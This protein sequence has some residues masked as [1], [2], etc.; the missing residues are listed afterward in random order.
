MKRFARGG[1]ALLTL[2]V[3]GS[4]LR[5]LTVN[6]GAINA[7]ASLP[8]NPLFVRSGRIEDP[9]GL[10]EVVKNGL[11]RLGA[12]SGP[13]VAA[14]PGSQMIIR[15]I[16]VPKVKGIKPDVVVPGEV[17]RVLGAAA[18]Q[19][20]TFW[21]QLAET[22]MDYRY[23]VL[24]VPRLDMA[25]FAEALTLAGLKPRRIEA[26]PLALARIVDEDAAV[27]LRVESA[28]IDVTAV[29][30]RVPH[31]VTRKNLDLGLGREDLLS[32]IAESVQ[33]TV[34]FYATRGEGGALP[35]S[36]PL[37]IFGAH[38]QLDSAF[39]KSVGTSSGRAARFP[40]T[41][42]RLLEDFPTLEY[43]TNLG[44]AMKPE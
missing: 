11:G 14:F 39:V 33:T 16:T 26:R 25:R 3:E 35:A 4:T 28:E 6:D 32:E 10:A 23:Y 19:R 29:I 38:P 36:A 37:V 15:I 41:P 24:G 9:K 8:F 1:G 44:L 30:N 12:G 27:I 21:T 42:G 43:L 7:Y 31:V 2:S 18:E 13:V 22:A 20:L 34:T 17:Q 5:L 40:Q